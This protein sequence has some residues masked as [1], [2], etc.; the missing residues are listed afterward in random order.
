M[1]KHWRALNVNSQANSARVIHCSSKI[2]RQ[3]WQHYCPH[4]AFLL[5]VSTCQ[6]L[7]F[8][9]FSAQADLCMFETAV[10]ST[11]FSETYTLTPTSQSASV[12]N[13]TVFIF[14]SVW[15]VQICIW[16]TILNSIVS[17]IN[18]TKLTKTKLFDWQGDKGV[19]GHRGDK[20]RTAY[21]HIWMA[22]I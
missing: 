18:Q 7:L 14:F 15:Q 19:T 10:N 4:R 5:S 16:R 9:F 20:V 22:V 3:L 12:V 1:A 11:F 2:Y 17:N 13:K 6:C 8:N 21:K